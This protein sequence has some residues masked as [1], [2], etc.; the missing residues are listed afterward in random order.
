[1]PDPRDLSSLVTDACVDAAKAHDRTNALMRS[2]WR[3][4]IAAA[5]AQL[6]ADG[7][8]VPSDAYKPLGFVYSDSDDGEY[9]QHN[10]AR[11]DWDEWSSYHDDC[12]AVYVKGDADA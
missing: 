8:V 10:T 11:P 2:T 6:V 7:K 9:H 1:M 4:A 3:D 5:L 12:R